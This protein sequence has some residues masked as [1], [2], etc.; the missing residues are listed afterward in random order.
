MDRQQTEQAAVLS[1]RELQAFL[2]GV[3]GRFGIPKD[4]PLQIAIGDGPEKRIV[5]NDTPQPKVH[6]VTPKVK[7]FVEFAT[8]QPAQAPQDAPV[9]HLGTDVSIVAGDREVYRMEQGAVQV[10]RPY[11]DAEKA[12]APEA[13]AIVQKAETQPVKTDAHRQQPKPQQTRPRQSAASSPAPTPAAHDFTPTVQAMTDQLERGPHVASQPWMAAEPRHTMAR[14]MTDTFPSRR[15]SEVGNTARALLQKYGV[16]DGNH[17]GFEADRY[18]ITAEDTLLKITDKQG[19]DL[20]LFQ[21]T[22]LG[23]LRILKYDLSA[24][25]EADFLNAGRFIKQQG[26]EKIAEDP[27]VRSRQLGAVAPVGDRGVVQDSVGMGVAQIARSYLDANAIQP[28]AKGKRVFNGTRYKITD[29]AGKALFIKA[30]DGRQVLSLRNGRLRS[31]LRPDDIIAF[32]QVKS[33]LEHS[34]ARSPSK[35]LA[36]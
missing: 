23:R 15:R 34:A 14:A 4:Q 27:F 9:S 20:A 16:V 36:R 11:A 12:V 3:Y 24:R 26:L 13:P 17:T 10:N 31:Q 8:D 32:S 29:V 35:D 5:Y 18:R 6:A 33:L 1:Q 28:D 19:K 21:K 30:R 2:A 22:T 25:Q 7:S